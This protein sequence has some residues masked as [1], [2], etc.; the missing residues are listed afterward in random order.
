MR[1]AASSTNRTCRHRGQ[2]VMGWQTERHTQLQSCQD[3][4]NF[5]VPYG[6]YIDAAAAAAEGG[7]WQF[8]RQ[9]TGAADCSCV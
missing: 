5:S 6:L 8:N 7:Y 9:N 4:M 3:S 1:A 2:Q